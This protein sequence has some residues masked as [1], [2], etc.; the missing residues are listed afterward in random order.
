MKALGWQPKRT[1]TFI[2]FTGEEWGGVGSK[3][4]L[5][6]HEGEIP[7]MDAALVLD[8]GTGRVNSIALENLWETGPMMFNIYQPLKKSFDLKPSGSPLL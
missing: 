7:K 1:L 4:F 2:L 6:T 8:T 3:L 5:K